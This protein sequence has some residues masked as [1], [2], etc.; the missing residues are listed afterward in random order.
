ML[1][2]PLEETKRPLSSD[3]LP[4]CGALEVDRASNFDDLRSDDLPR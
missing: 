2:I 3:D 1:N 4:V